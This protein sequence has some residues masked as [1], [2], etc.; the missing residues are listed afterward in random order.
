MQ[1]Y[2]P[3]KDL[4]A[5]RVILVTGAGD[6]IGRAVSEALA[7]HGA[8]VVLL[9]R[10]L[11]KLEQV[12]DTI[13]AAGHPQPA[14]Y[15]MNLEGASP[16]DYEDLANVVSNE[17]GR[18]DGLLHNAAELGDLRP[19]RHY[20]IMTWSK[21]L[22]TNLTAPFLLTQACLELLCA[23][24]SA[25]VVFSHDRLADEPR[26]YWGA[27]AVAKGGAR[28]LAGILNQELDTNT[29]VRVNLIDPGPV[30][31][32]LRLQAYPAEDRE[33]LHKPAD[34]VAPYLYLLGDDSKHLNGEIVRFSNPFV[35]N[36]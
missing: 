35:A 28:T 25:S 20:D 8:T 34:V 26:A 29:A 31:T 5:K 18:L 2:Q 15:P 6:G 22:Q 7:A 30:A 21:V 32:T 27:Y 4:L 12:Y 9:G 23:A 10:T 33:R 19:I 14:I 36:T 16:K 3:P 11:K 24:P 17:F 13:E 1:P